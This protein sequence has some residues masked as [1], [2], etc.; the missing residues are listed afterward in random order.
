[1]G[2]QPGALTTLIPLFAFMAMGFV[3]LPFVIFT[4]VFA[5]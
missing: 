3:L 1:M 2:N 4:I 5:A